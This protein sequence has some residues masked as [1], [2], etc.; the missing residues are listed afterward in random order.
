MLIIVSRWKYVLNYSALCL[1]KKT[2]LKSDH[3]SHDR[4]VLLR[5]SG[6]YFVM[7][8]TVFRVTV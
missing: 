8:M 5:I 4:S 1:G 3:T 6:L 2:H 7:E